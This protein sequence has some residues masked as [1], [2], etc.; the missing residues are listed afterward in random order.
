MKRPFE[1]HQRI[2]SSGSIEGL[3]SMLSAAAFGSMRRIEQI[4]GV[5][6]VF[7]AKGLLDHIGVFA[8]PVRKQTRYWGYFKEEPVVF[9]DTC[10]HAEVNHA[11]GVGCKGHCLCTKAF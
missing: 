3:T 5:Y 8:E 6:C 1:K 7:G 9:C 4:D 11:E 10:G 2:A